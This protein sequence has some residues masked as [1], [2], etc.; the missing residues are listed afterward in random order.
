MFFET[1]KVL[2]SNIHVYKLLKE[3]NV[4]KAIDCDLIPL[5]L[6][7]VTGDQLA[8]PLT[9]IMNSATQSIL[10]L[11]TPT[12]YI[13]KNHWNFIYRSNCW[14][15]IYWSN[16][17]KYNIGGVFISW[18]IRSNTTE[19]IY[20]ITQFNEL[21]SLCI[22]VYWLKLN[23]FIEVTIQILDNCSPRNSAPCD[24]LWLDVFCVSEIICVSENYKYGFIL[25]DLYISFERVK[26]GEYIHVFH[27]Y[28]K[29]ILLE[30]S[31]ELEY[32]FCRISYILV[33]TKW[34]IKWQIIFKNH[35]SLI[36]F[37]VSYE[38][39]CHSFYITCVEEQ[40]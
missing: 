13:F 34:Q 31:S 39:S 24:L 38:L 33:N 20:W 1:P 2:I 15:F 3:I 21:N 22:G 9:C 40:Y 10:G 8:E 27:Q 35:N 18:W 29:L 32:I 7:R 28:K 6:S 19:L 14:N 11:N 16:L 17:H 5:K 37:T 12:Q 4:N 25:F 23:K 26:H 30:K 36:S